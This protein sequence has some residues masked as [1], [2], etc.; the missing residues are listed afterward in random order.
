M[1]AFKYEKLAPA[2]R[3]EQLSSR[4]YAL[5]QQHYDAR[6]DLIVAKNP[7]QVNNATERAE[8]AEKDLIELRAEETSINEEIAAANQPAGSKS[9]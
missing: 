7:N 3:L 1:A 6:L 4:L 9:K 8:Q 5:E 2:S